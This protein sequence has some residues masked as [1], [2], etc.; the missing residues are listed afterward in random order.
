MIQLYPSIGMQVFR[1]SRA[2]FADTLSGVGAALKG[3]RW[4]SAGIEMVYTAG[5]RSLAM[6][7]VAVHL[8]LG[9]LPDD[10][11]MLTIDIPAEV[12]IKKIDEK[13]LPEDW[14]V[15]PFPTSTQ[16]WG[17]DFVRENAF[18]VMQVPSVVTQGD[19]NY[20]LNPLHKDF[21]KIKIVDRVPFPFDA[22]MI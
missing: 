13:A 4:N 9:M 6:A 17:D 11:M 16:K 21:P 10:Y 12:A 18:S 14:R 1:L 15:F 20:L 5:N 22:R 7:E 8:S 2:R 19:Y 3:A